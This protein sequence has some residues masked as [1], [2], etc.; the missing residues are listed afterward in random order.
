MSSFTKAASIRATDAIF[1]S[2]WATP[3][4]GKTTYVIGRAATG[5]TPRIGHWPLPIFV[6][7]Y[8]QGLA[9]LL[10]FCEE[11]VREQLF[12]KDLVATTP[13]MN[14]DAGRQ[15][16][17]EAEDAT[18]DALQAIK[19]AGQGTIAFDTATAHWQ[20][21]QLVDLEKIAQQRQAQDKKLY[22]FDY[23]AANARWRNFVLQMKSTGC[24]IVMLHHASEVYDASGKPT[25]YFRAQDN[26]QQ[27]KLTQVQMQLTKT[28]TP[29]GFE[30]NARIE[31]CRLDTSLEG[32]TLP[33]ATV[34]YPNLY[35]LIYKRE[36]P[37]VGHT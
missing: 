24:N 12:I 16:M 22:P 30:H 9:E 2:V 27:E 18:R 17:E 5:T 23:S 19:D 25:G 20:L 11:H 37:Y 35:K 13:F 10:P 7:N 29:D 34:D 15:M 3:K 21:T 26:S 1:N 32:L 31:L 6:L 4:S 28:K 36:S 8:D 33:T 14:A